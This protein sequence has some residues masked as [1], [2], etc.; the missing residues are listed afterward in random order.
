M[1]RPC[2]RPS[3]SVT[4]PG[5]GGATPRRHRSSPTTAGRRTPV[6]VG[7][8]RP[9]DGAAGQWRWG[10][11][12]RRPD[13]HRPG[14]DAAA[15]RHRGPRVRTN[16]GPVPGGDARIRP[17][18]RGLCAAVTGVWRCPGCRNHAGRRTITPGERHVAAHRTTPSSCVYPSFVHPRHHPVVGRAHRALFLFL[19]DVM[20]LHTTGR[21]DAGTTG[22]TVATQQG[23]DDTIAA[24][25]P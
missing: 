24:A 23:R 8:R 20:P 5:P 19:E 9:A 13:L 18:P 12:R 11:G 1:P 2:H 6:G 22:T 21:Q 15:D 16:D 7:H 3:A 4:R 25:M 17:A 10:R 14:A